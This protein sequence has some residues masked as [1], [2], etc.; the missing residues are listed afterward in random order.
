ML[1]V[2]CVN[3][4][5]YL[6]R[7]VEYTNILYDMVRRNLPE[8]FAGDFTVF[9]D[10]P[11]ET[12]APGIIARPL[13]FKAQGWWAK[14]GLFK[15]D[16]FP[17]GER[18]LF[19][20]L[21]TL[22]C[23]PIDALA[24]YDGDFAILQDF[25][26]KGGWQSSVMAWKAGT[27]QSIFYDYLAA[28]CPVDPGGDQWWIEQCVKRPDILQMKF[29]DM[30][31]SYKLL[32]GYPSKK[33]SIIVFHGQPRPH[34]V[35]GWAAKVW[36]VGGMSRAE[37]TAICNTDDEKLTANVKH[38]M[39]LDCPWFDFDG[40]RV[41]ADHCVIVGGG[42][43]LASQIESIRK[44]QELGQSVWATNNAAAFLH[45]HGI[46]IDVQVILDARP[47]N[48][49]FVHP[50]AGTYLV[51]SQADPAV[52]ER[53]YIGNTIIWHPHTEI[54]EKAVANVKDKPVHLIGGGTTVGMLSMS[55]AFLLGYRKIHLY[56]L[57]SC[58][59]GP[60]HHAYAQ[61]LNDDERLLDVMWNDKTYVCAPWMAGQA[62]E[63]FGLYEFMVS[64]GAV[65]TAHGEGLIPDMCRDLLMNP[66]VTAADLRV[67]E[68]VARLANTPSPKVA[69][70]GV[71]AG[72]MSRRLLSAREDLS[73]IM[74]DSWEGDGAAYTGK[75]VDF[76]AE[77]SAAEQEAYYDTAKRRVQFANGRAVIK[78]MRS[79]EAALDVDKVDLAFLDADHSYEGCAADIEA[80]WPKV[81]PGGWLGFHDYENTAYPEWGVKRAVDEFALLRGLK[82]EQGVNFTAFIRKPAEE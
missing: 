63:F 75:A 37:L 73:L 13:P 70:I 29:P 74:V 19:F 11:S 52:F 49:A 79:V 56:G 31:E 28:G 10:N 48:A 24:A 17:Y 58:Y 47:E 14:L 4:G 15:E 41:T 64:E 18:V 30:F 35:T 36:K 20:D 67:H 60:Q 22:I 69:E 71:F 45:D 12:Y 50:A 68:V 66:P 57:D 80:W 21:D 3:N 44:R 46:G 78:R 62:N 77:L 23:G 9:T 43:S 27:K 61:K 38:A 65:I 6:G 7:G 8:G 33:A 32:R 25:F 5:N 82:V 42:P 16:V 26:R 2:C 1:H 53:A 81:K 40:D 59:H 51:A 34:E 39:S 76:H 72:D 54:V 55:L